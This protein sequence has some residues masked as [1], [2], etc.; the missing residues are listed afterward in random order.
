MS[1]QKHIEQKGAK[2]I[3]SLVNLART[4]AADKKESPPE[5][6][7]NKPTSKKRKRLQ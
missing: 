6:A 7:A 3:K 2:S 4:K 5:A 1:E